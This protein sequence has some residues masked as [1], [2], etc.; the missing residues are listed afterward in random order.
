VVRG[1]MWHGT[2]MAALF[3]RALASRISLDVTESPGIDI[4]VP[5]PARVYD[6]RLG[7]KDNYRADREAAAEAVEIF[8]KT[9]ESARSCRVKP[10]LRRFL[11]LSRGRLSLS[12]RLHNAAG[13]ELFRA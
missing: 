2:R 10:R 3:M 13:M 11:L 8:P 7:G 4:T 12:G 5:H 6:Y 9:V 1:F